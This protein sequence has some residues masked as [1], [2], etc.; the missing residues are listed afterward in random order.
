MDGNLTES[1]PQ[2]A[3]TR[4]RDPDDFP[5][6]YI[7]ANAASLTGQRHF[8]RAMKFRLGGL[9]VAALAGV[10]AGFEVSRVPAGWVALFAFLL[11]VGAELYTLTRRPDRVWYEGRAAAESVKTLAWRFAVRGEEYDNDR[12]VEVRFRRDVRSLLQ[13]LESLHLPVEGAG[14]SQITEAMRA[15]RAAP[16][17]SRKA[18][19]KA[20]R[21][22]EQMGWYSRK[23][24]FNDLRNHRWTIA[25]ITFEIL[26]V[27][28]AILLVTGWVAFDAL[29]LVS[30]VAAGVTAWTQ[31]KQYQSLST[32]YAVTSQELADVVS[33]L[34]ALT[35]ESLW[36]KFVAESEE[37]ISREH[38]LWRASR[39]IKIAH[40]K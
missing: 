31:A 15:C 21:I 18:L 6:L 8:M 29:G 7:S 37:A 10:F 33:E 5:A 22:Q 25:L 40:R 13:D 4:L 9:L 39:G 38:T 32:A 14:S 2:S 34:D 35:D 27:F 24:R 3:S 26:G 12:D 20:A 16:F 36:P 19:Y 28:G 30:A 17:A 11:A 23:A 1:S